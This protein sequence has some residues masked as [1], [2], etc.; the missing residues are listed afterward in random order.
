MFSLQCFFGIVLILIFSVLFGFC[1][2][3]RKKRENTAQ[4]KSSLWLEN[5]TMKYKDC[6]IFIAIKLILY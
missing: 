3:D 4:S 2:D 5:T 6:I 1:V